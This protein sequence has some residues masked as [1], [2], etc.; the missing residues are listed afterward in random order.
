MRRRYFQNSVTL[1]NAAK[2]A[3]PGS[4]AFITSCHTH[5]EAQGGGFDS[6]QIAGTSM[7]EAVASWMVAN[8]ASPAP[9]A[10]HTYR[11][12]FFFVPASLQRAR[13]ACALN[14]HSHKHSLQ[15]MQLIPSAVDCDYTV[16]GN[17]LCNAH[18]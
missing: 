15:L 2:S 18:C 8:K 17:H 7:M 12:F 11:A 13:L 4:G 14:F 6:F 9:S 3:A 1:I 16:G 10:A 5:C